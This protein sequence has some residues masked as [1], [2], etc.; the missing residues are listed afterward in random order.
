MN[1][2]NSHGIRWE[3]NGARARVGLYAH[4]VGLNHIHTCAVA[5][6]INPFNNKIRNCMHQCVVFGLWD[7]GLCACHTRLVFR[8][9]RMWRGIISCEEH[10]YIRSKWANIKGTWPAYD[11]YKKCTHANEMKWMKKPDHFLHRFN[12]QT[13][14]KANEGETK[15][16]KWNSIYICINTYE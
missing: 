2:W 10:I 5:T 9:G 3:Q 15:W 12:S 13:K 6:H 16:E 4:W 7:I 14:L 8:M 11:A 1:V